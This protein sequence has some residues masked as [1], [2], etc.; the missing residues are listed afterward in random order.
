MTMTIR[1]CGMALDDDRS[2]LFRACEEGSIS[3]AQ[4]AHMLALLQIAEAILVV[5]DTIAQIIGSD[6]RRT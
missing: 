3:K 1:E 5:G 4:L 6:P 2:G